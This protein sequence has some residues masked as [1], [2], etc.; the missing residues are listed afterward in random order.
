MSFRPPADL[1]RQANPCPIA[2][3]VPRVVEQIGR[4]AI[5]WNLQCASCLTG[6]EAQNPFHAA[7]HSRRRLDLP[8]AD[9]IKHE[10]AA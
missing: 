4:R 8:W 10:R 7:D 1:R 3:I 5:A 2:A 6:S 9:L